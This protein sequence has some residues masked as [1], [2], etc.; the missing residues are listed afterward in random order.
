MI[1]FEIIEL[2]L[3]AKII[4]IIKLH[5]ARIMAIIKITIIIK[6]MVIII[7]DFIDK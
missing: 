4:A 7:I 3:V 6:I 2:G 1:N 5:F